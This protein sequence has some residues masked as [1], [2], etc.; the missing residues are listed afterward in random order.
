MMPGADYGRDALQGGAAARWRRNRVAFFTILRKEIRR[1]TRIWV[2]TL[3]PSVITTTLYLLIF[4]G[5]IG[6]RIG[7]ME[8]FDYMDY[9]VP[10]V[11]MLS[12]ITNSYGNV[13]SSFFGTK[14]QRH[15]EE[16]L[17]APIPN[18]LILAGFVS[19]GVAR[20]LMVGMLV[21]L[22]ASL[23][24]DISFAYPL[25]T[26]LV[27]ILTAVVFALGGFINAMFA[28]SFDDVAIVPTFVLAP[29]TYLGGVFYSISLLAPL[30]QAVSMANPILYM[31]NAFR[32]A[33][34]GVADIP[35]V[36]A[37]GII[38]GFIVILSAAALALLNRGTGIKS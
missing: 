5:L 31:V 20:G 4:G 12:I 17:V 23:F 32:Y 30:W 19:G 35:V 33:F 22:V 15:I 37:F 25:L 1:F 34:L 28:R 10:G 18:W 27:A 38:I 29:L 8:G 11:I 9:I 24:T 36:I 14:F 3:L 16:L 13:V 2:Q 21:T 26:V 7:P 6:S